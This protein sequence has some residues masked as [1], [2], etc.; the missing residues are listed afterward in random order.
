MSVIPESGV[1][2]QTGAY[3]TVSVIPESGVLPEQA[4]D[5]PL[6]SAITVPDSELFP[7]SCNDDREIMSAAQVESQLMPETRRISR[8]AAPRSPPPPWRGSRMMVS[9]GDVHEDHR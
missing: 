6:R 7:Q 2:P 8:A 1:F 3:D 9:F 5:L 4:A